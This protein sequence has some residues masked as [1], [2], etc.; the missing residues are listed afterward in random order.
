[1]QKLEDWVKEDSASHRQVREM[2]EQQM[3]ELNKQT[4]LDMLEA[5][6]MNQDLLPQRMKDNRLK[7]YDE[8]QRF[9][10]LDAILE[11]CTGFGG[12]GIND[13]SETAFDGF[14]AA[15]NEVKNKKSAMVTCCLAIMHAQEWW[16]VKLLKESCMVY[17]ATMSAD[18]SKMT[19][20]KS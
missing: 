14:P 9:A 19:L 17:A 4:V 2:Q 7:I 13:L 11:A 6:I 12:K 20:R 16:S 18:Y 8:Q 1:M 5:D 10:L 15:G 3:E